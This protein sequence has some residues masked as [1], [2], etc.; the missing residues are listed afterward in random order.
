M[1]KSH[2]THYVQNK[3]GTCPEPR[4]KGE[5]RGHTIQ[6]SLSVEVRDDD[7]RR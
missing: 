2:Y 3:G 1:E 5:A 7:D 4:T 6:G